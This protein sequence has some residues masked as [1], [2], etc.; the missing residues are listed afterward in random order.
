MLNHPFI[1]Y[2][3]WTVTV[4]IIT[5]MFLVIAA[6]IMSIFTELPDAVNYWSF[7]VLMLG[8]AIWALVLA[9][10]KLPAALQRKPLSDPGKSRL[11]MTLGIILTIAGLALIYYLAAWLQAYAYYA[12]FLG[13]S[14]AVWP[15]YALGLAIE[16]LTLITLYRYA[17]RKRTQSAPN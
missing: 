11:S 10:S 8:L 17:N 15:V 13:N 6:S 12:L 4:L 9:R 16:A 14:I 7:F 5:M 2:P 1:K 3:L